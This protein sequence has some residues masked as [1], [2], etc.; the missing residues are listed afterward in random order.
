MRFS[1]S[2]LIPS[3]A[4]RGGTF[5]SI[6][7]CT[8]AAALF[9]GSL[10]AHAQCIPSDV[11]QRIS[12]TTEDEKAIADCVEQH[13]RNL[14]SDKPE[15]IRADR[16]ELLLP[17]ADRQIS[18]SFR[19]RYSR[20]LVPV[21]TPLVSNKNEIIAINALVIAGD[22]GTDAAVDVVKSQ[23][24]R[25]QASVRYQ[26][27]YAAGRS[28]DTLNGNG[29]ALG[30]EKASELLKAI[31]DRFAVE[32]DDLVLDGLVRSTLRAASVDRLRPRALQVLAAGV[33]QITSRSV[34]A[35]TPLSEVLLETCVR[36][37]VGARDVLSQPNLSVPR[38]S[39]VALGALSGD[40]LT[41][42]ETAVKS[43]KVALEA[44]TP[45]RERHAQ[46]ALAAETLLL[47]AGRKLDGA[48][49]G[50]PR[51]AGKSL[52]DATVEG[53][54]KFLLDI[55]TYIGPSGVLGQKPFDFPKG[56]FGAK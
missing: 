29:A 41:A 50:A 36:A 13:T 6:R 4:F 2:F 35:N 14:G 45:A 51:E 30:G 34:K 23:L 56:R 16:S 8:V 25:E 28:F 20:A 52:R 7:S 49:S 12:V 19:L 18:A 27:S 15:L 21:L 40:I 43:K 17:L 47:L 33:G 37:A 10:T 5:R 42:V 53:D 38:E 39:I 26:A 3:V 54:V 24:D 1:S 55:A 32:T 22:L 11:V 48:F 44:G 31:E 9:A 46:A